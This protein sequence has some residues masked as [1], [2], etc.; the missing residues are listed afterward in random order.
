TE[1]LIMKT[2]RRDWL[3][4]CTLGTSTMLLAPFLRRLH[5]EQG[6]KRH[7][8]RFVFVIEGNGFDPYQAQPA[9]IPRQ[10]NAQSQNSVETL[11]DIALAEH[12]LSEAMQPLNEFKDRLTVVQGLSSRVCGGGH[13]N[14]FGA[15]GVYSSK[16]GALDETI[17]LALSRQLPAI[18]PQVGL[19][20]SD[21]SEHSIIYNTS[22]CGPGKKVPT[23]CRPDLAY[24]QL[25]GS[26][27]QGAA[28][29][30]FQA[31]TNLLDFMVDDVRRLEQRLNAFER[32]QLGNYLSSYEAM[33]QRQSM[34]QERAT[35]LSTH[36][37]PTKDI[38][39][40][41]VETDRLQAQFEIGAAALISGLTNVLTLASGCGD[42]YFSVKFTG[43]GIDFGKHGIG[44]GGSY[45]GMTHTQLST[46]IRQFHFELLAQ[47]A[48]KLREMPEGDGS[49]LD[50]TVIV[51]L[52]DAAEGHHSRCW[53]W[54]LVILGDLGGRLKTRGRF[55]CYPAYG[56]TGHRTLANLYTT[57]LHAVGDHRDRFGLPDPNLQ[58]LD[59]NG[60]LAELLA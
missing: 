58:D 48:R 52:S 34:L 27:A 59:Q 44:H 1:D 55:L 9:T 50:N 15:L 53:E 16:A 43:L 6:G 57:F 14:N 12:E 41:D 8:G 28:A 51:Y 11:Q 49:M 45:N 10:K 18:F 23:Q 7:P 60:P 33:R 37:P 47:L 17:D 3:R 35:T 13:S 22:A 29:E 21:K 56:A 32:E 38:F 39:F 19:G 5:A 36:C 25:F 2:N 26:V 40:S 20:I 54:P 30:A 46:K 42:P 24:Q 31:K 4:G